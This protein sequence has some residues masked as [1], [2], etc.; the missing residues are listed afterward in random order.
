MDQKITFR[1]ILALGF[2]GFG[3]LIACATP[4]D[5]L[6]SDESALAGLCGNG[7]RDEGEQCDDGNTTN[8]DGCD[9]SCKF[10]Q[11]HRM[12][13]LEMLF[14]TDS[15]CTANA[16]GRA[17]SSQAH[18]QLQDAL[19]DSVKKGD[20]SVMFKFMNLGDLSG[21]NATNVVAGSVLGKPVAGPGYDGTND[22]DWW[23]TADASSLDANRNPTAKITGSVSN[24][25]LTAGPGNL[26]LKLALAGAPAPFELSNVRVRGTVGASNKPKASSN[27][28][29][30]GHLASEN[31][32]PALSSFATVSDGQMCANLSAGSLAQVNVPE[33][34]TSGSY[35]CSQG[36]TTQNTMLDLFTGGCRVFIV[37]AIAA[38]QPDQV[39][40]A[41]PPGGKYVFTRSGT[42]VTGCKDGAGNNVAL[43]TCLSKASYSAAFKFTTDR[44]IIK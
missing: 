37:N 30:P 39:V 20:V 4:V 22:L 33:E 43:A 42:K 16:I 21:T 1:T 17:I 27:G 14:A 23:Y 19:T 26:T 7:V 11:T 32:D 29:T 8:L 18:G 13:S 2:L 10:E 44:V 36:Y 3:A 25:K 35:A 9:S 28:R 5:D 34:L 38:T 40:G 41:A 31:L 12:N 6:E 15:Y 24:R